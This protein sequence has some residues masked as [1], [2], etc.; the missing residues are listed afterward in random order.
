MARM[1]VFLIA[2]CCAATATASHYYLTLGGEQA[3]DQAEYGDYLLRGTDL[4]IAF[5]T[6]EL[7]DEY[8]G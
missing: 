6:E 5:T 1:L 4:F 3:G 8:V 2:M 7:L